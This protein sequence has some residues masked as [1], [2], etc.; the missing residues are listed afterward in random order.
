M[1]RLKKQSEAR[2]DMLGSLT[3]ILLAA[4]AF[5]VA[6]SQSLGVVCGGIF[7][8]VGCLWFVAPSL[9]RPRPPYPNGIFGSLIRGPAVHLPYW[10]GRV[11]GIG[12][13]IL[14]LG[15]IL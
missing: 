14:G 6:A 5:M 8:G 2:F 4:G 13:V 1:K 11:A 7:V 10:C 15:F 12:T 3:F 9:F